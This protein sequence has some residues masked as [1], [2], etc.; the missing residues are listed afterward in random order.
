MGLIKQNR[1]KSILLVLMAFFI[2]QCSGEGPSKD[3][4]IASII[5]SPL[6]R[7][8]PR[9]VGTGKIQPRWFDFRFTVAN[10]SSQNIR[11]EDVL[12]YITVDGEEAAPVFFDLGLLTV[13]DNNGV[14]YDYTSYC[15]YPAGYSSEVRVCRS[16]YIDANNNG[17]VNNVPNVRPLTFYIG[18]V[19][20]QSSG[21]N[22]YRVKMEVH[23]VFLDDNGYDTDR[24]Y[25]TLYFSTR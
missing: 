1:I 7:I 12:F 21:S 4:K 6:V 3:V 17:H 22:V 13:V 9:D 24:L 11:I 16:P 15:I 10:N 25:K 23:G 14:S 5:K 18:N 20:E 2:A 8:S 19:P